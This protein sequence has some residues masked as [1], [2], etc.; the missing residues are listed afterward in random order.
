MSDVQ[1]RRPRP[2][3]PHRSHALRNQAS[4]DS[5]PRCARGH[6]GDRHR[7]SRSGSGP[8]TRSFQRDG[9]F[10]IDIDR[11]DFPTGRGLERGLDEGRD[12]PPCLVGAPTGPVERSPGAR[13]RVV[14]WKSGRLD[15][16]VKSPRPGRRTR[17]YRIRPR[18]SDSGLRNMLGVDASGRS[19][20]AG[21]FQAHVGEPFGLRGC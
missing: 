3:S 20:R 21:A 7:T 16:P 5:P 12:Q 15:S 17:P 1:S 2:G 4:R 10:G 14:F 18:E 9:V 8:G 19:N 11:T 13:R 6:C